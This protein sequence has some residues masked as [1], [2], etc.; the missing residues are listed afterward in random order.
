MTYVVPALTSIFDEF[1]AEL[2]T[3]TRGLINVS[4][5]FEANYIYMIVGLVAI[6]V[7]VIIFSRT[8]KGKKTLDKVV[9]KIPVIGNAILKTGLSKFCRNLSMMVNSGVTIFESLKHITETSDNTVFKES[10]DNIKD[11]ITN[12]WTLAQAVG[13]DPLFPD[14]MGEMIQVGE[15]SGD[16]VGQLDKVSRFYD[17]EAERALNMVTGML[18]PG[19]TIV[20]GIIIG[21]IAVTVFTS[22]YSM[23]GILD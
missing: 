9:L 23:T 17:R 6:V 19:L 2:P 12:G 16:L 14:L 8:H 21:L 15:E 13:R 5:F 4:N 3:L 20:V 22:I 10:L 11:D 7:L 18:T 1:N